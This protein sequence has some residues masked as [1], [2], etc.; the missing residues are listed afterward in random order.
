MR[1][2]EK[3]IVPTLVFSVV[4][5]V[6]SIYAGVNAYNLKANLLDAD[7]FNVKVEEGIN[8]YVQK[9]QEQYAAPAAPD[10][11][12][13]VSIDDDAV[14][15]D[16]DAPVTIVEFS[17]FQCPYCSRHVTN[18]MPDIIENY[19]DTGKVKYIFRD[20]PLGFHDKAKPAAMAAECVHEMGGAD[21]YWEYHDTLF[22]NQGS[23]DSDSLK[24]YA[25]DM[26]YDIADCLDS[27][28]YADEV[29]ADMAEGQEY[30]VQGTPAF[31]INGYMI[32]GALP[33]S[34]FADMID[35]ELAK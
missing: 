10:T 15:G 3:W 26:G 7:N 1:N 20:F 28:K 4:A 29:D 31:F 18:T 2:Y 35:A 34:A 27:E 25:S 8:A 14:K 32:S 17:D 21:A 19:I 12:I 6:L 30:G 13:E 33:Y 9:Q 23:L 22:A 16:A 11:P 24:S 5:L